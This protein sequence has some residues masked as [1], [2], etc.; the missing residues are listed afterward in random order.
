M[1]KK[2]PLQNFCAF[3]CE[4]YDH[5]PKKKCSKLDNKVVK[6]IFISY[7]V[8]V[9]GYMLLNPIIGK[10]LYIKNVIFREVESSPTTM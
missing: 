6:C 5:V 9:K 4:A 7:V 2:P 8:G 10:V 3:G 1:G